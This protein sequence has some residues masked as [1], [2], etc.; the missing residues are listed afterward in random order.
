MSTSPATPVDHV[1]LTRFNLPSE[2]VESMIRAREGWLRERIDLFE[3]YTVP[4]LAAQTLRDFHWIVYLDPKSPH[5]LKQRM[6]EHVANGSFTALYRERVLHD[7]LI[8]D[9][10]SVVPYQRGELITTNIDNDDGL[11]QDFVERLQRADT[12]DVERT[13]LYFGNGLIKSPTALFLRHDPVNAFCSVREPWHDPMTCWSDWHN[14][15][16]RHMSTLEV[17]GPPAWLQVV[18]GNNVSNRVRG[19]LVRPTAYSDA[20]RDLIYDV[21]A[22][23]LARRCRD[24]LVARPGRAAREG[25]RVLAKRAVLAL[26]GKEALGRVKLRLEQATARQR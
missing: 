5:W 13:A 9:L 10:R 6:A 17:G 4:S 3:R 12:G 1:F 24:R 20:F 22:P 23:T 25:A 19:R 18:H 8:A 16:G 21:P 2:G 26:G 7:D 14:L 15:L 11:A